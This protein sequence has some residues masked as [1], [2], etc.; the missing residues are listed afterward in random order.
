MALNNTQYDALMRIYQ[1]R[2]TENRHLQDARIAEVY[3]K[4]PILS[5]YDREIS[6]VSVA[7]AKK[8]ILGDQTALAEL[9]EKLSALRAEKNT[10]IRNAGYEPSY[11]DPIYTCPM[12]KDTGYVEG[13]KCSCLRQAE[14]A[15]LYGQSNL[16]KI[17]ETE[18][19]DKLSMEYYDD[20]L[21][22]DREGTISQRAYMENV[23]ALCRSYAEQFGEKGGNLL[24][25]GP[26]GTGK[27]FL[28]TCI[29]GELLNQ[30][31]AVL[32]LTAM[33]LFQLISDKRFSHDEENREEKYQGILDCDLLIIDDLGT[34]LTNSFT[35]SEL[36][37]LINTRNL[38]GKSTIISTNLNM[39]ELRN[40]YTERILSRI[41][42]GYQTIPL[43]GDDIRLKKILNRRD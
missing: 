34:E 2:Q 32:Y 19:F 20:E 33:D 36:F 24:F 43:Y 14:I 21:F 17:L 22:I 30:T 27:S 11:L 9:R 26:S 12:C 10:L 18:N 35:T 1:K 42:S 41:L 7:Q 6:H 28:S 8:L 31:R 13:K 25:T 23:V 16:E 5:D 39:N 15:I 37:Y 3:E 40:L 29:G 38:N 4:L